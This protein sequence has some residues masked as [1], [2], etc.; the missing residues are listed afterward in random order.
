L[1][2]NFSQGEIN[3]GKIPIMP[4]FALGKTMARNIEDDIRENHTDS[5]ERES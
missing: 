2:Y 4:G 3:Y 5:R 1:N